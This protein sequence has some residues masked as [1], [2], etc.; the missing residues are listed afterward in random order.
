MEKELKCAF[1][2]H[3]IIKITNELSETL[4]DK[5]IE[6]INEGVSVFI[7]GG[8]IGF[9]MF[10]A[11]E[12]IKLKKEYPI[13]LKMVIPCKDQTVKWNLNQKMMYDEITYYAD[14]V[15]YLK[16]KYEPGCMQERNRVMVEECDTLISYCKRNSGGTFYTVNYAKKLGKEVIEITDFLFE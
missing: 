14:E 2:G 8:A 15:I 5:L 1:T 9:D 4:K 10:C 13:K 12:V 6:L 7:N 3:R 16:E 11:F